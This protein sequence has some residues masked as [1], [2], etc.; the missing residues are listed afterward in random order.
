MRFDDLREPST[1]EGQ[2][3]ERALGLD[4]GED[5][6]DELIRERRKRHDVARGKDSQI[7][8]KEAGSWPT[9]RE[10]LCRLSMEKRMKLKRQKQGCI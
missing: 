8:T 5:R 9:K 4:C 6:V 10:Q 2:T 1:T 7:L 3:V